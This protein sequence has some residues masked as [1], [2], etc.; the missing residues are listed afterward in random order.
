MKIDKIL[1]VTLDTGDTGRFGETRRAFEEYG[2]FVDRWP[3]EIVVDRDDPRL[4]GWRLK[5]YA[6]GLRRCGIGLAHAAL[7]RKQKEEGWGNVLVLQDDARPHPKFLD[8]Y[9]K[10]VDFDEPFDMFFLGYWDRKF[11]AKKTKNSGVAAVRGLVLGAHAYVASGKF[12]GELAAFHGNKPWDEFMADLTGFGRSFAV[13]PA[14][15]RQRD[16]YSTHLGA[17]RD[18]TETAVTCEEGWLKL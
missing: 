9:A 14:C 4:D 7:H 8:G 3:G 18:M 11:T 5:D 15:V 6:N 2:V 17:Y 13:V 12:A 1:C 16:N 10:L